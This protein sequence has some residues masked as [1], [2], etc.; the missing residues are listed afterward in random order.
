[1]KNKNKKIKIIWNDALI[2]YPKR[3]GDTPFL[4]KKEDMVPSKMETIGFIEMENN[5]Y[6]I[7][8]DPITTNLK[9]KKK[10]PDTDKIPTF[11]LIPKGMIE[12]AEYLS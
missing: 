11:Y 2:S 4:S 3:K 1:M 9:T 8:K 12:S 5:N 7:I 6:I 10:H